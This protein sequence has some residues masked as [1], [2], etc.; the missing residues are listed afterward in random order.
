MEGKKKKADSPNQHDNHRGD[1]HDGEQDVEHEQA[2]DLFSGPMVALWIASATWRLAFGRLSTVGE[3]GCERGS[4]SRRRW[5]GSRNNCAM[6]VDHH[7]SELT[8]KKALHF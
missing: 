8:S 5:S 3:G 1:N 2:A 6:V 7:R 4:L